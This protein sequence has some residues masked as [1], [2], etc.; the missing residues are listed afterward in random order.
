MSSNSGALIINGKV[1]GASFSDSSTIG[2]KNTTVEK[3][4]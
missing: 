2:Y 4:K 3:K 1:V